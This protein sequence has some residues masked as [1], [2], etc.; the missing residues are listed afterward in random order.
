LQL[1]VWPVKIRAVEQPA[2]SIVFSVAV[3]LPTV[4]YVGGAR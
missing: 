3:W 2:S 1:I 4:A